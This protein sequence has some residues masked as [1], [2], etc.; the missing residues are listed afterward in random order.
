MVST[1]NIQF[2]SQESIPESFI[3]SKPRKEASAEVIE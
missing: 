3:Y 1:L 2:F